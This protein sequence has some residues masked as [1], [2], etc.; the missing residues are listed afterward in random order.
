[1]TET[2]KWERLFPKTAALW[3]SPR[4][5]EDRKLSTEQWVGLMIFL[6]AALALLYAGWTL[7]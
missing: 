6:G 1:M 2:S 5:R 3:R 4:P 7:P